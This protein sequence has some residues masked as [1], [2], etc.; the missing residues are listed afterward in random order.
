MAPLLPYFTLFGGTVWTCSDRV[1]ITTRDR[2]GQARP[3]DRCSGPFRPWLISSAHF[4]RLPSQP[5]S[6]YTGG[7]PLCAVG[8]MR[9]TPVFHPRSPT[10]RWGLEPL[11]GLSSEPAELWNSVQAGSKG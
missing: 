5:S 8:Q 9:R 4:V 6:G 10:R 1:L 11:D 2:V 7:G 3:C